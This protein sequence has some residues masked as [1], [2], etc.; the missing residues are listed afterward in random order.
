MDRK[1][2]K[3]KQESR[4]HVFKKRKGFNG[5]QSWKKSGICVDTEGDLLEEIP[6]EDQMKQQHNRQSAQSRKVKGSKI[7]KN[8]SLFERLRE[9]RK[10]R[11]RNRRAD[12]KLNVNESG[13][14]SVPISL[15]GSRI[16]NL[17]ILSDFVVSIS[18]H[19]S[20]CRKC[21]ESVEKC[22]KGVVLEG[23]TSRQGLA[24]LLQAKCV[25]CG[26]VFRFYTSSVINDPEGKKKFEVNLAACWGSMASGGGCLKLAE[27]TSTMGVPPMSST[28][29]TKLEKD[30]GKW[31]RDELSKEMREAASI[32]RQNAVELGN[33]HEEVPF[34]RVIVDGGWSKRSHKHAYNALGGVGIIIG[35]H[36]SKYLLQA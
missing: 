26:Q 10:I 34:C 11:N 22:G 7:R 2:L 32:E 27:M 36:S 17:N 23:E 29:F 35:A 15:D 5:I 30:I 8:L 28:M 24:S 9:V 25:G 16:M 13:E 12:I 33:Y 14:S 20:M 4:G 3:R 19:S 21:V 1:A 18:I 31:W 6:V